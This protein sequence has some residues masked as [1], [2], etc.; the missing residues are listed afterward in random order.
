MIP[1]K[2]HYFWFG[3][4]EKNALTQ[5]CIASWKKY[6]PDFEIIEW[7]EENFDVNSI[8]YTEQAYE[9]KKWA[10]VSDYARA[11]ILYEEG[12]FY[13][14]TDMETKSPLNEFLGEKAICGFEI[15]GVPFSAFWAVEKGHPLAK[16]IKEYY[17]K[18]SSFQ[19]ITNTVIFSRLLVEKYGADADKD[20]FQELKDGIKLYPSTHFSQDLPRNF[21]TH[22]FSGSWHGNWSNLEDGYKALV[23]TYGIL[24]LVQ[25]I[26][27]AKKHIKDV[28]YNQKKIDI[29]TV[30]EQIPL[31]YILEFVKKKLISKITRR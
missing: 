13:L 4:G 3:K 30:L 10:F 11:K 19:E 8:P 28:V 20:Q 2:I 27:D 22:H 15:K 18:E 9:K 23:N 1:K 7:T 12:G 29:N 14:D 21:V 6:Q 26:P 16:D 17:E 25:D 31:R 24:K 5:H